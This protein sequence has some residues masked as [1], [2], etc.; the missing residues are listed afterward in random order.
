MKSKKEK[1]KKKLLPL[2]LLSLVFYG[3]M[4]FLTLNALDIRNSRLPQV[5]ANRLSKQEFTYI[6]TLQSG[7]TMEMTTK[8]LAI[9]KEVIEYGRIFA[10]DAVHKNDMTYYYAREIFVEI[11]EEKENDTYY[12]LKEKDFRE[13]IVLTG[14]ETLEDGCEVHLVK[15]KE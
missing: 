15:E 7:Q 13:M 3:G 2:F 4:L 6:G 11:D 12:A 9:P 5:T 14:Y 10:I 8:F 1:E